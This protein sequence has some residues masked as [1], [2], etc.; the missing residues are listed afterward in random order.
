MAHNIHRMAA[1]RKFLDQYRAEKDEYLKRI[2]F[3]DETRVSYVNTETKQQSMEWMRSVSPAPVPRKFK[4]TFASKKVM[5]T[6]FWDH[7]GALLL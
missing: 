3:G 5:A 1:T 2:V 4:Q 6:V 7:Q